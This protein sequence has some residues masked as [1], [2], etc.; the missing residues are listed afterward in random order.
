MAAGDFTASYLADI[1]LKQD[2]MFANGRQTKELSYP[3]D[4]L[5]TI[6]NRQRVEFDPILKGGSCIAVN[7]HWLKD[8]SEEDDSSA[9]DIEC[10]IVGAPIE[11]DS[12]EYKPNIA[13]VE[14]FSVTDDE[15][16]DAF[17][18]AEKIAYRMTTSK[19]KL[20]KRLSETLIAAL[21]AGATASTYVPDIFTDNAGVLE[22][23]PVNIGPDMLADIA[24][25]AA[26]NR[27]E[28]VFMIWGTKFWQS[29]YNAM[30]EKLNDDQ[31][32]RIAKFQAFDMTWDPINMISL[33]IENKGLLVEGGAY[34][35]YNQNDFM[36]DV[37]VE[38]K[39]DM[40]TWR[41]PLFNI[42]HA[43]GSRS[44]Q[45]YIDVRMTRDCIIMEKTHRNVPKRGQQ[46]EL[47][48]SGG[49]H[50]APTD[51]VGGQGIIEFEAVTPSP[52][53]GD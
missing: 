17:A 27:L 1:Q 15:C 23:D 2:K 33:G 39:S 49:F 16:R 6:L 12:Q 31:R 25:V 45:I 13:L 34:G 7:A 48:L 28:S 51:C 37:P 40:F 35:F 44:E 11:S 52:G 20:A 32:D 3:L 8:C 21:G 38:L 50:L 30:F 22:F 53:G 47:V 42:T 18:A 29:N 10:E 4:A 46:F 9:T 26:V 41:E 36:S 43:N 14:R 19:V 5:N 24:L